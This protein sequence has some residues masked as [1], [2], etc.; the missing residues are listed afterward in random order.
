LQELP[1][2]GPATAEKIIAYREENGRFSSI[3]QLLE[4]PGIGE[5]TLAGLRDLVRV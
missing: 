3:D 2:V 5:R 4:V 1:R